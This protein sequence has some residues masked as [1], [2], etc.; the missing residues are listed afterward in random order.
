MKWFCDW[1]WFSLILYDKF[2]GLEQRITSKNHEKLLFQPIA[3]KF[4][5]DNHFLESYKNHFS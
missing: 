1:K 2:L 4:I 3:P 5:S